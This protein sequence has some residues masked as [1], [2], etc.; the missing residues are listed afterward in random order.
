MSR[1]LPGLALSSGTGNVAHTRADG[2]VV[3]PLAALRN[4]APRVEHG[5]AD[6]ICS[7]MM[8]EIW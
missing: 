2:V 6:R 3:V 5:A 1:T 8:V 4:L 7:D